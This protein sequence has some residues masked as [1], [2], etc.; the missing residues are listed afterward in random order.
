MT[1][2]APRLVVNQVQGHSELTSKTRLAMNMQVCGATLLS[3]YL[4]WIPA[5]VQHYQPLLNEMRLVT[6]GCTSAAAT[7][8]LCVLPA[9]AYAAAHKLACSWTP[10]TF[11]VPVGAGGA[12]QLA[13]LRRAV[14]RLAVS[15]G[16]YPHISSEK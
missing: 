12:R 1:G 8:L 4:S 14:Q 7:G 13:R 9:Q 6:L 5:K 3:P 15:E 11:V 2:G 16:A 10:L